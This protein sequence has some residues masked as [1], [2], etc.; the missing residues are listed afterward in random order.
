MVLNVAY[1]FHYFII[2]DVYVLK[3]I[4]IKISPLILV[5]LVLSLQE[6]MAVLTCAKKNFLNFI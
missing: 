2:L 6:K 3:N 1:L 5:F 4:I